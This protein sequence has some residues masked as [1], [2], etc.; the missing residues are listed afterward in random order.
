MMVLVAIQWQE[1]EAAHIATEERVCP[2]LVSEREGVGA[3]LILHHSQQHRRVGPEVHQPNPHH[4]KPHKLPTSGPMMEPDFSLVPVMQST[5]L[6]ARRAPVKVKLKTII[7]C[8]HS[9]TA[10]CF[11]H[12]GSSQLTSAAGDR[13][14]HT[15]ITKTAMKREQCSSVVGSADDNQI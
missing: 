6:S 3:G 9:S 1:E 8:I 12:C 10:P 11:S 2:R 14:A 4:A 13:A 15:Y 7:D 5:S